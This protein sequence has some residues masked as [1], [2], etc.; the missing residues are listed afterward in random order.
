M[1]STSENSDKMR[2]S[3]EN[4]DEMRSTS[5]NSDKKRQQWLTSA[6]NQDIY[7]MKKS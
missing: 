5:E 7:G 4:S 1:R 2:S 6:A 3:S